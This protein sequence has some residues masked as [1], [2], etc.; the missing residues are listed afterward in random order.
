ML[1]VNQQNVP[2]SERTWQ[3]QRH[4][5]SQQSFKE[6]EHWTQTHKSE[7]TGPNG[8]KITRHSYQTQYSSSSQHQS[9]HEEEAAAAHFGDIQPE[10]NFPA[11]TQK[12]GKWIVRRVSV[13]DKKSSHAPL[14]SSEVKPLEMKVSLGAKDRNASQRKELMNEFKQKTH[15]KSYEEVLDDGTRVKRTVH[16]SGGTSGDPGNRTSVQSVKEHVVMSKRYKIFGNLFRT[17]Q[18]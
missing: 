15:S 16:I 11:L 7:T 8:E 12:D 2:G 13:D 5:F 18:I 3:E 17:K 4:G 9:F 10:G 14:T 6:P 1:Q